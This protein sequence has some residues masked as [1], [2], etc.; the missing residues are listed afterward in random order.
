[1][2]Q[3]LDLLPRRLIFGD[4]ERAVARISRDGTRIA[5]LAPVE[6]WCVRAIDLESGY[7]RALTKQT[8]VT[9]AVQQLSRGI[10]QQNR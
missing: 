9:C 7:A 6:N 8:G 1:M 2:D 5:F 3:Q 10:I 4:P